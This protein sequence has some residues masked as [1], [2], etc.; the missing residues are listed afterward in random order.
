LDRHW[1]AYAKQNNRTSRK[2]KNN[3]KQRQND[4]LEKSSKKPH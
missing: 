3:D 4:I 1:I 2:T